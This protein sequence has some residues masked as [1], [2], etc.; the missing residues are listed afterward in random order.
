MSN[1]QKLT[2]QNPTR[3]KPTRQIQQNRQLVKS[4]LVKKQLVKKLT[5]QN[6]LGHGSLMQNCLLKFEVCT[7]AKNILLQEMSLPA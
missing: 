5:R 3:Q 4:Q 6:Y 7:Y 2:R 1:R